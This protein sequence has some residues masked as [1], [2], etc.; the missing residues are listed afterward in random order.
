M[1]DKFL[2]ESALSCIEL[3]RAPEFP[4]DLNF[5]GYEFVRVES[6]HG[7]LN[8]RKVAESLVAV[9]GFDRA[10]DTWGKYFAKDD[11]KDFHGPRLA[12]ANQVVN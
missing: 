7:N 2:G 8:L 4:M 12:A 1:E 3:A 9:I 10:I 5:V 6:D 11:E